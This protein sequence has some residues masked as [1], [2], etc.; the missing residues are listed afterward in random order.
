[1]I[2]IVPAALLGVRHLKASYCPLVWP[3]QRLLNGA[4]L[5]HF[6]RGFNAGAYSLLSLTQFCSTYNAS[7]WEL[8]DGLS[9]QAASSSLVSVD[10]N[11]DLILAGLHFTG[12]DFSKQIN[13]AT[14]NGR[15]QM[16]LATAECDAYSV[17]I[18]P[19]SFSF[20]LTQNFMDALSSLPPLATPGALPLY[21]TFVDT[22]GTHVPEALAL[23]GYA[24]Q[25][26]TFAGASFSAMQASVGSIVATMSASLLIFFGAAA[27]GG[28]SWNAADYLT[29]SSSFSD[30]STLCKP[31]CPPS[32]PDV[33]SNPLQWL[34]YLSYTP[35]PGVSAPAPVRATLVP[36][37]VVLSKQAL[38][39][40]FR[41][42]RI[43]QNTHD[44]LQ[45]TAADLLTFIN[46][47]YCS[48]VPGCGTPPLV[49][50]ENQ[51]IWSALPAGVAGAA[52]AVVT[53]GTDEALIVIGGSD[54][55]GSTADPLSSVWITNA[56]NPAVGWIASNRLRTRE[57]SLCRKIYQ[58]P[59]RL[60]HSCPGAGHRLAVL[61]QCQIKH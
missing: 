36:L 22:F 13:A 11:A 26:T 56:R 35:G 42:G 8:T 54:S 31:M 20:T 33:G 51:N 6:V 7:A 52:S 53:D 34:P 21:A 4:F 10:I 15:V 47:T 29:F 59:T 12:S 37:P 30:N 55:C 38:P 44:R 14:V 17:A 23:G 3:Q 2:S 5:N 46:T 25:M 40:A 43:D 58:A 39:A 45:G 32:A 49:P 61:C 27:N 18:D 28:A 16:T 57:L 24:A 19:D 1:M 41:A 48:M 50:F 9:W 60:W